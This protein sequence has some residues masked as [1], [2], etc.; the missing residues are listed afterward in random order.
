ML[1]DLSVIILIL[2]ILFSSCVKTEDITDADAVCLR[3][4]VTSLAMTR[5][6]D[7]F[8]YTGTSAAG[9]RPYLCGRMPGRICRAGR[10]FAEHPRGTKLPVHGGRRK[11]IHLSL[12]SG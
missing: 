10:H 7:D 9:I 12:P 3:A 8:A 2:S 4:D 1:M 5:S 11:A 6:A